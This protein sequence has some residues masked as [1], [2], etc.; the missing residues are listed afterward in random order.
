MNGRS[1]YRWI[2][3]LVSRRSATITYTKAHTTDISLP[4]SLNH[5]AD[6][7]ASS[8][9]K[10][11]ALIPIAPSPTFFMDPYTFHRE[12]D[13]WIESNI[14]YF[15]DHFNALATADRLA[16]LPK[17]RMSTWLYDPNPPPPWIYTKAFSAYTALIQ[18]YVRSGQLATAEGLYQKRASTSRTCRFGCLDIENPHH[19]FVICGRFD[20]MQSN[21]LAS[22]TT[23]ITRT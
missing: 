4:A 7:Y 23:T 18:L 8:A 9:Q 13:G 17:H 14:R 16:L 5:E 15:I 10:S 22:L 1:Y 19:I 20:E 6:H 3:D 12:P 2:L 11:I 21:Q